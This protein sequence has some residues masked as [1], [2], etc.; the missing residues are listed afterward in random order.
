MESRVG[1]SLS[2]HL[3]EELLVIVNFW[4]EDGQINSDAHDKLTKLQ[5][6]VMDLKLR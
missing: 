4:E 6:K 2:P 3:A 1:Q 5:W